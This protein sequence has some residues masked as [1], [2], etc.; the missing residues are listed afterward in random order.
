MADQFLNKGRYILKYIG[1]NNST[2]I[3]NIVGRTIPINYEGQTKT[4]YINNVYTA[5]K[6]LFVDINVI[7]NPA[8]LIIVAYVLLGALGAGA[9]GYAFSQIKETAIELKPFLFLGAGVFLISFVKSL[10]S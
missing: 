1:N 6:D 8:P 3:N 10:K 9:T 4:V 2:P 7:E 5:G